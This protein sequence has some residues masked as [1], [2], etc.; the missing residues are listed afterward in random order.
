MTEINGTLYTHYRKR[1][2]DFI[3]NIY[4][5]KTFMVLGY[6]KNRVKKYSLEFYQEHSQ[7]NIVYN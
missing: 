4:K 3:F 2:L 5:A 1:L 6:S 7:E